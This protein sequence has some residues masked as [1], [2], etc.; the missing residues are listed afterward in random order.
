MRDGMLAVEFGF[1]AGKYHATPWD[2]QVNEGAVE[3]PPSPWRILRALISTWY[4]K[5]QGEVD[6][7][8]V[9]RLVEKLGTLPRYH[10]P[11]AALGHTRHYM[12]LF[13]SPLNG[14]TSEI[15]DTFVA[16]EEGKKLFVFWPEVEIS[17][18]E[19]KALTLLLSRLGYLGRAES[20]AE[21]KLVE[22]PG[23]ANSYPLEGGDALPDGYEGVRTLA[24]MLPEAYLE[25]RETALESHK[26]RGLEVLR[27]KARK[28]GKPVEKVKLSKKDIEK[29]EQNL[30]ADVFQALHVETGDLK[31]AGWSQPP[32]SV[33][34]TYTRPRNAFDAM[35]RASLGRPEGDRPT[36]ARYAV[37]SQ[38]PP[39]LT[40]A[41]SLAER[42]HVALVSRSDGSWAFTG[43]DD[44]GRPLKGHGHA[45]I[46]CE[47]NLGLGKG[48]RG[49]ITHVTVYAPMGFGPKE[50]RALDGLNKVWDYSRHDVQLVLLGMGQPE[51]FG[52][53]DMERGECSI[54]AEA[55]TWVSR[56]PF[57]PTR[58]PKATRAGVPKRD[59]NGLQIGG[60]EHELRRLL[61]LGGFPSP[62]AVDTVSSTDLAGH[63]TRWLSFRRERNGGEGRRSGSMGYGFRI[64]FPES[65]RGPIVLGYGAHFGLGVFVPDHSDQISGGRP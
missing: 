11:E 17:E 27:D 23:V 8:T 12:P 24:P 56:T 13:R 50:R 57:M 38:A 51:D 10:L 15:F 62:T 55:K 7:A 19:R 49:E 6:E 43:C 4:H 33:W 35:P 63:E 9:R 48:R 16:L 22:D 45:H 42:I 2:R 47:S 40:D 59:E 31:K 14:K 26:E 46:L 20:W 29:I 61:E 60:P 39:R 28:K 44:S 64:K 41:V 53:P 5:A 30:P 52:G 36:V 3:W 21:A 37:A 1:P 32:G 54:L 34:V 65:V 25:W 18:D 58:H